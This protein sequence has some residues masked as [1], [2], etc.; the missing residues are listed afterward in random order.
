MYKITANFTFAITPAPQ[1]S[2]PNQQQFGGNFLNRLFSGGVKL[3]NNVT[4]GLRPGVMVMPLLC[5]SISGN[6]VC[7]ANNRQYDSTQH[8]SIISN[9]N[10]QQHD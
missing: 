7:T 9:D 5:M 8:E 6:L 1:Q 2:E 3:G 4:L 10:G